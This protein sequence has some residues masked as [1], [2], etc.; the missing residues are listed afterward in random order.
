MNLKQKN[1][2]LFICFAFVMG[3][4]SGLFIWIFFR[5]MNFSIHLLWHTIPN[6]VSIPFYTII[7]CIL[8]GLLIGLFRKKFGDYP[9]ELNTVIKKV[10]EEGKYPYHNILPMSV[11]ALLPL[12]FGASIGPEAGLT[13]VIAGLCSW[14]SD[15]IKKAGKEI[16]E[17]TKLGIS[18]TLGTI[19]NSPMFGFMEPIESENEN[20]VFPKNSKIIL[21]FTSILGAMGIFI[22]L[23]NLF[24][25]NSGLPSFD[26]IQIGMKEWIYLLPLILIGTFVG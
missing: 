14:V 24:G 25:G 5:I 8:G 15:K 6:Y 18:A 12:I 16:Q 1:S 4:C 17:F 3:A 11:S 2:L 13:G 9:E 7:L 10:K 22:L 21:Y 26:S 23:K 20:T 19:F